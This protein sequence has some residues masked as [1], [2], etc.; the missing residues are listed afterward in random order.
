MEP[1]DGR[2]SLTDIPRR[3]ILLFVHRCPMIRFRRFR[4]AG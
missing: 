3:F 1:R 4:E 2:A